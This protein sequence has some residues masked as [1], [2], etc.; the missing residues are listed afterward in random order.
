MLSKGIPDLH[1]T[2][3]VAI[4]QLWTLGLLGSAGGKEGLFEGRWGDLYATDFKASI[5]K[6]RHGAAPDE[7]ASLPWQ[8]ISGLRQIRRRKLSLGRLGM[9][10]G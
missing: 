6:E 10:L 9:H 8:G 5:S 3:R 2:E 1:S 7:T 4:R